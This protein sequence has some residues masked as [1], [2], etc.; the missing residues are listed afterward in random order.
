M[1]DAIESGVYSDVLLLLAV[2]VEDDVQALCEGGLVEGG[3]RG[4]GGLGGEAGG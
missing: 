3:G 4:F 1:A 2:E